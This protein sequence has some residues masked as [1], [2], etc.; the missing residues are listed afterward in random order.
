MLKSA[1]FSFSLKENWSDSV[2]TLRSHLLVWFYAEVRKKNSLDHFYIQI[3]RELLTTNE[4]QGRTRTKRRVEVETYLSKV[5]NTS[6]KF[7]SR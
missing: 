1:S 2:D 4:T 6:A 7:P 3:F 5:S